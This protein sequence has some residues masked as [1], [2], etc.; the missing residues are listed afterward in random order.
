MRVL[1]LF[2]VLLCACELTSGLSK[3]EK[4][5]NFN[6]DAA[7]VA[8]TGTAVDTGATMATDTGTMMTMDTDIAMTDTAIPMDTPAGC[9][10]PESQKIGGKCYFPLKTNLSFTAA[11]DACVAKGGRLAIIKSKALNDALA[12]ID[13]DAERWIGLNK[14]N[15]ADPNT[16]DNYKWVDGSDTAGFS[17]W[18]AGEPSEPATTTDPA[19]RFKLADG[20][21]YDRAGGTAAAAGIHALCEK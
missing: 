13:K 1:I 8:D 17:A 18:A 21:W 9:G 7:A 3:L 2:P 10:E 14:P 4:D 11:K 15:A 19:A 20:L 12:T 5:P 16:P 6:P